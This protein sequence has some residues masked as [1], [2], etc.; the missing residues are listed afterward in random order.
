MENQQIKV[1][2][3]KFDT[4]IIYKRDEAESIIMDHYDFE[5]INFSLLNIVNKE[6]QDRKE[7]YNKVNS[8]W[9][10]YYNHNFSNDYAIGKIH[11]VSHGVE[12]I[13]ID[14]ESLKEKSRLGKNEGILGTSLFLI[15]K[16][17]GY[18][19]ITQDS[20]HICTKNNINKYF[21]I[22]KENNGSF[23]EKYNSKNNNSH[24]DGKYRFFTLTLLTPTSLLEQIR[25]MG[26]IEEVDLYPNKSEESNSENGLLYKIK[27]DLSD[28]IPELF[29]TKVSITGING[30]ITAEKIE[31]LIVYLS[32]SEKYNQYKLIGKNQDGKQRV[33][34]EDSITKDITV[35]CDTTI[36]G[37]PNESMFFDRV[38][39][40][41]QNNEELNII[42]E[43]MDDVVIVSAEDL[44]SEINR[45]GEE[46]DEGEK[47]S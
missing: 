30:E 39:E 28:Y 45:E 3:F 37:W 7:T 42:R 16:K 22:S 4:P 34:S 43:N 44:I 35:I 23:R 12:A 32:K 27:S 18:L 31:E 36:E 5:R 1:R 25:K 29:K 41:I 17:S 9:L 33:F 10:D 8:L 2:I 6:L 40:K 38:I 26:S 46:S 24:I 14:L 19:Y 15:D 13:N 47:S 11:T 20:N 21:Y